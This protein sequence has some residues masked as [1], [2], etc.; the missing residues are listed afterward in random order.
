MVIVLKW[1][2]KVWNFLCLIFYCWFSTYG[3]FPI[4]LLII[5]NHTKKT[6]S[7]LLLSNLQVSSF[8]KSGSWLLIASMNSFNEMTNFIMKI[9]IEN[10]FNTK[11]FKNWENFCLYFKKKNFSRLV[12]MIQKSINILHFTQYNMRNTALLKTNQNWVFSRA[13]R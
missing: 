11:S 13:I 9:M 12:F 3:K 4:W 6:I 7:F 1:I 10:Y 8:Q 2:K 5:T